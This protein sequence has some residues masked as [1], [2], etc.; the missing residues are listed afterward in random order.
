MCDTSLLGMR[1]QVQPVIPG[2]SVPAAKQPASAVGAIVT[3]FDDAPKASSPTK[4]Q[5]RTESGRAAGKGKGQ[6]RGP[7]AGDEDANR[8]EAVSAKRRKP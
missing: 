8:A 4:K 6:K 3:A 1:V 7:A 2:L 5:K